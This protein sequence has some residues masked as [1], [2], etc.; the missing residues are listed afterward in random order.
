M[1]DFLIIV[2]FIGTM[3]S[4]AILMAKSNVENHR[5]RLIK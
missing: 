3:V 5:Q 1:H 4:P 2:A